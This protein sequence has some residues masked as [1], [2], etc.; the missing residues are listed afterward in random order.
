MKSA[1]D[2]GK[3]RVRPG[4]AR[5]ERG[6]AESGGFAPLCDKKG[7]PS[8]APFFVTKRGKSAGTGADARCPRVLRKILIKTRGLCNILSDRN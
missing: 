8:W 1:G 7:R 4:T 2:Y 5:E 3:L 6:S